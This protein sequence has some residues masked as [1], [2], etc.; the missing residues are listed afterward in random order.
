[1]E[2]LLGG[3]LGFAVGIGLIFLGLRKL[4]KRLRILSVPRSKI[5]SAAIG[6]VEIKGIAKDLGREEVLLSPATKTP[7]VFYRWR[8]LERRRSGK[9]SR[10]VEVHRADSSEIPFRV[11]DETGSLWI[12]PNAADVNSSKKNIIHGGQQGI[13]MGEILGQGPI[14]G[15]GIHP[16][17][18]RIEE[19]VF[20]PGDPIYALGFLHQTQDFLQKEKA[21]MLHREI[22]RLKDTPELMQKLDQ[23]KDGEVSQAEWSVA[24]DKLRS[25]VSDEIERSKGSS[26]MGAHPQHL[27]ILSNMQEN[28]LLNQLRLFGWINIICG[29]AI[30]I[31]TSWYVLSQ[32][33]F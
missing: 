32:L 4:K 18:Y 31:G 30:A 22:K 27:Y 33:N 15:W 8:V 29:A 11:Q 1:M 16:E 14:S 12:Y 3:I 10:W 20:S 9:N 28:S 2:N 25:L 17:R 19:E 26:V 5:A 23:N 6:P 21:Q 7:C 24:T 13:R